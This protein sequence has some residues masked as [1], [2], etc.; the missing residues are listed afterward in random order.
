M[1]KFNNPNLGRD[2]RKMRVLNIPI[3][4]KILFIPRIK[5]AYGID[6]SQSGYYYNIES[7]R[8]DD[9]RRIK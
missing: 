5:R 6:V 1:K 9:L 4:V 7:E 8:D 3:K 2:L